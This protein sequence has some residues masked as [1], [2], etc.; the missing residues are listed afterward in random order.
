MKWNDYRI[1]NIKYVTNSSFADFNRPGSRLEEDYNPTWT[2]EDEDHDGLYSF[3]KWYMKY[4]KD[5]TETKF[6]DECFE[7]DFKHWEAFKHGVYIKPFYERIRR[8]A[9]QRNLADVMQKIEATAMDDSNKS[10][11]VALKY[12]V[13]RYSKYDED[14][15]PKRG[16]PKK[17]DIDKAAREIAEEDKATADDLKRIMG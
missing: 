9:M 16:R 15:A 11:M 17:A 5:P 7:G 2:V 8:E 4:R 12:L 13:D 6:V 14:A 10:Q 3:K 1:K